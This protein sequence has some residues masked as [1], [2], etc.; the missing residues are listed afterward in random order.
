MHCLTCQ[1]VQIDCPG[2]HP[3]F[4]L[5]QEIGRTPAW[6]STGH[7]TTGLFTIGSYVYFIADTQSGIN[8]KTLKISCRI[9][10]TSRVISNILKE[11]GAVFKPNCKVQKVV[12]IGSCLRTADS[13][14]L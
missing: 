11:V 12:Q 7:I 10:I 1:A 6:L 8:S 2:A 4:D 9:L 14:V 5:Q 3:H 13:Q